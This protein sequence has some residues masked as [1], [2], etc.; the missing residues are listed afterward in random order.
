MELLATVELWEPTPVMLATISGTAAPTTVL[1]LLQSPTA[2]M[3]QSSFSKNVRR[4]NGA[5]SVLS[6][7]PH[8]GTTSTQRAAYRFN[9]SITKQCVFIRNNVITHGTTPILSTCPLGSPI[10]LMSMGDTIGDFEPISVAAETY[11]SWV[12]STLQR[13]VAEE[14]Q[15]PVS[16]TNPALLPAPEQP[17]GVPQPA[18]G[19]A[20]FG[21]DIPDDTLPTDPV[22]PKLAALRLFYDLKP[23]EVVET[24]HINDPITDFDPTN[25]FHN[26]KKGMQFLS[27][28]N[29]GYSLHAN[30][31]ILV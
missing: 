24:G 1:E 14:T 10:V 16:T 9:K 7:I 4:N 19:L 23:G 8:R 2:T 26:W 3:L 5:S 31:G 12:I 21:L 29:E 25:P 28:H 11:D 6:R 30:D 18:T 13:K 27:Q 17:E 22:F 20:R 15:A